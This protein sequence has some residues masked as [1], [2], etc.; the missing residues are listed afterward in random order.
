[1]RLTCH[2]RNNWPGAAIGA[3]IAT[4]TRVTGAFLLIGLFVE[5]LRRRGISIATITRASLWLVLGALPLIAYATY[6][7]NVRGD[8]LNFVTIQQIGWGREFSF[9]IAPLVSSWRVFWEGRLGGVPVTSGPRLFWL[10]EIAAAAMGVAFMAWAI[11]KRE[12]GYA[13]YMASLM[14]VLLFN[15][16]RYLSIPRFLLAFLPIQ[17]FLAETSRRRPAVACVIVTLFAPT[18]IF[19]LLIYTRGTSCFTE[20]ARG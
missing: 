11:R 12:W 4:G 7:Q 13:A 1:M 15:G 18:S 20:V 6:L 14:A 16:P 3:A 5:S 9:P 17:L 10:S 19:G 8:A 2:T